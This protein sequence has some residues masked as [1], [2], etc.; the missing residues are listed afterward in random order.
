MKYLFKNLLKLIAFI[1]Y[2][3][4]AIIL[5]LVFGDF[6]DRWDKVSKI[7]DSKRE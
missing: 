4:I 2:I 7:I 5:A 1:I 3:P 6:K